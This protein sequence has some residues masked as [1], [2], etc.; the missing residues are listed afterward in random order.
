MSKSKREKKEE[1]LRLK[2]AASTVSP[3]QGVL[4]QLVRAPPCHGG[5]CGFE[6]RRLR[7]CSSC[8]TLGLKIA[9]VA[10][11]ADTLSISHTS[12]SGTMHVKDDNEKRHYDIEWVPCSRG[13][14]SSNERN[15][16]VLRDASA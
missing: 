12:T 15:G 6:P 8:Y 10:S 4:A 14:V 9:I 3:S 5:G 11:P 7:I 2:R 13:N 16:L 1:Q